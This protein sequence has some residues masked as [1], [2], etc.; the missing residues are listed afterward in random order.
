VLQKRQPKPADPITYDLVPLKGA[1]HV[2]DVVAVRLAVNGSDWK[3]LLAED[4]IPAGT[5]FLPSTG[6]YKLNNQP[7]WW[8][9]GIRARSFTTTEWPSSTPISAAAASMRTC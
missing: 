3:Y 8:L 7:S 6:L 2:G 9:T 1:V 4:P 5:E